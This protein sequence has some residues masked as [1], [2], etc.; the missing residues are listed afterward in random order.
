MHLSDRLHAI[1]HL[2]EHLVLLLLLFKLTILFF[3]RMVVKTID[4][5]EI[6][7]H[8]VHRVGGLPEKSV[9]SLVTEI[10]QCLGAQFKVELVP[11]C[12]HLAVQESWLLID[13]LLLLVLF[14]QLRLKVFIT[15][16]ELSLPVI[17]T[18]LPTLQITFSCLLKLCVT[19]SSLLN[20][21][22]ALLPCLC[23]KCF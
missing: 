5:F 18:A 8:Y 1:Y 14:E 19:F 23:R 21:N 17:L 3:Q 9:I 13:G 20:K 22:W 12:V 15:R 4:F 7:L 16:I 11:H 6:V 2:G 10:R